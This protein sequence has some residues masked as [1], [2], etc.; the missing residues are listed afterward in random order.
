VPI[1]HD[2]LPFGL[3]FAVLTVSPLYQAVNDLSNFLVACNS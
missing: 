1:I 3:P 2:R